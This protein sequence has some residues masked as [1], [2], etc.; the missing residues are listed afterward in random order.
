MK[1]G[2]VGGTGPAGTGLGLRLSSVGYDVDIGSRSSGRA[3]EVVED[4][5][6]KWPD[7][8]YVLRGVSNEEAARAET[9][10]LATP[11]D[12]CAPTA[13]AFRELL[14]GKLVICMA[15]ALA[16]VGNEF[17]ALYPPRGS[18]AADVQAAIPL[19][20]VSM[21]FQHLPAKELGEI[22]NN[23]EGDVLV[24]ADEQESIARTIEIV[25]KMPNLRGLD[26]G[27]LANAAP[28]EAFT[29]VLLQLNRLYKTRSSVRITGLE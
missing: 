23:M 2:I 10:V 11:W 14:K 27:S 13:K 3:A 9:V 24:C 17:H 4:T 16:R 1:I 5:L 26:C 8:N 6:E 21:A 25:E 28:V 22:E 29:A 19:S 7:N 18:I 20:R 15:N 12:S